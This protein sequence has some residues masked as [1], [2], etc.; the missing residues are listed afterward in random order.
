MNY[1]EVT[2]A[3]V[4]EEQQ[5]Q[6]IAQLSELGFYGFEELEQSLKAFISEEEFSKEALAEILTG[7][8]YNTSV[9]ADQNWN[10][11]W[12][13]NFDPVIVDDFVGIRANFHETIKG[14]EHE[15]LITPKMSFGTGHH[16][17]TFTVMQLMRSI[18]FN[19]KTVFDFGSGT[20]ILAILAEKLGAK[21]VLAIDYDD[22]CIENALENVQQNHCAVIDVVKKD[23]AEVGRK[24]DVVIANINKNIILDNIHHLANDIKEG[25]DV[26][27]SGLLQEDE[28]DILNATATYGWKHLETKQKGMWIAMKY[29]A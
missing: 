2:I 8:Q 9:I 3:Q 11:L 20:G 7:L 27:L 19:H 16:A 29:K 17:T 26:I 24:F 21:E 1:I 15:I 6:F 22:W 28:A 18:D 23:T 25:G 4:S 14:M 13:S 12:E 10:Q 5:Q